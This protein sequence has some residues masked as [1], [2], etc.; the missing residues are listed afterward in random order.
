MLISGGSW[1]L[2]EAALGLEQAGDC[3]EMAKDLSQI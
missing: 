3:K 1:N 2:K